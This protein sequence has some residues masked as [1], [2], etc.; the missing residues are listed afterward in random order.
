MK[1]DTRADASLIG[2]LLY[3]YDALGQRVGIAGSL[4]RRD[5]QRCV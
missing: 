3:S 1:L 5:E 2:D 4:A